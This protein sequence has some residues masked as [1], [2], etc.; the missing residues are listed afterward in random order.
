MVRKAVLLVSFSLLVGLLGCGEAR[1]AEPFELPV[2]SSGESL[3]EFR[4]DR[5][6]DVIISS[7]IIELDTIEF[8]VGGEVHG[9]ETARSILNSFQNALFPMAHA[10]PGHAA[11]GEVAGEVAGPLTLTFR[12][13]ENISLGKGLFLPGFYGG[14]NLLFSQH[15]DEN[16]VLLEGV[17]TK[18]EEIP[19]QASLQ[20]PRNG[21]VYGGALMAQL[22][23]GDRIILRFLPVDEWSE[24]TLLDRITFSDLPRDEDGVAQFVN[25]SSAHS[26]LRETLGSHEFYGSQIISG[27]GGGS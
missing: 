27:S 19:F 6:Y 23:Q 4:T 22:A 9:E 12:S 18:E 24:R 5:G 25:G 7:L 2:E 1:E 3:E 15:G 11:G 17:A 10:H 26:I 8:T 21:G 20:A 16:T 14:Y 13:S